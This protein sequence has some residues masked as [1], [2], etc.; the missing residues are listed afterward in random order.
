MQH[1]LYDIHRQFIPSVPSTQDQFDV[2]LDWFILDG[3]SMVI[4]DIIHSDGLRVLLFSSDENLCILS[5]AEFIFG[6]GTFR[7]CPWPWYQ[8][9]IMPNSAVPVVFALL[10]DKSRRN[11]ST[12]ICQN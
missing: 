7:I 8:V 1:Q 5:R 2:S 12:A 4:A 9:F 6:D 3:K 11:H 10:P